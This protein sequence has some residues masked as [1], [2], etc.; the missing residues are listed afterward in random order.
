MLRFDDV[1]MHLRKTD[2][3]QPSLGGCVLWDARLCANQRGCVEDHL[4]FGWLDDYQAN[5]NL[6]KSDSM[7]ILM[8]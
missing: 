5:T 8:S 2:N 6:Y 1:I 4:W 3:N 7:I